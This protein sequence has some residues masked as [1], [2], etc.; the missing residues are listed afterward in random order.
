MKEA[1]YFLFRHAATARPPSP[2]RLPVPVDVL[3]YNEAQVAKRLS[4][5]DLQFERLLN[6]SIELL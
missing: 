5:G 1:A 3:V 2:S 6:Q 4:S